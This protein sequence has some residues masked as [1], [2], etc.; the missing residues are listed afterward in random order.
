MGKKEV[1]IIRRRGD[2][3]E[4]GDR[5]N[6]GSPG[7]RGPPGEPGISFTGP[8]GPYGTGF[9]GMTGDTGYTGPTGPY[10]TGDTGAT[11]S[12][13][14]GWTGT[15]G[16]TGPTGP[17]GTGATG[18]TGDTG[19]TGAMGS[20]GAT[21]DTG[22]TGATGA[23]GA[24]GIAGLTGPT[25]SMGT[26]WTGTTGDTGPTGPAGA[27]AS[28]TASPITGDGSVLSPITL[29]P[30]SPPTN[31]SSSW[32]YSPLTSAW[33]IYQNP[34][35]T[36]TTVGSGGMFPSLESAFSN[37]ANFL[38]VISNITFGSG[39]YTLPNLSQRYYIS[40][41]SGVNLEI[42]NQIN[43]NGG[44]VSITGSSITNSILS[45]SNVTTST[46]FT[47]YINLQV[48]NLNYQVGG[49]G[50]I[51]NSE[52]LGS[53]SYFDR[54]VVTNTGNT[55]LQFVNA[56]SDIVIIENVLI[57]NTNGG[58]TYPAISTSS[59]ASRNVFANNIST[60][61]Q[62]SFQIDGEYGNFNSIM[63]R[64]GL[65]NITITGDGNTFSSVI[66]ANVVSV[67]F[68]I[69]NISNVTINYMTCQGFN[70]NPN[71][72]AS[73]CN[74]YNITAADVVI[75]STYNCYFSNIICVN[76]LFV[77]LLTN[78]IVD[79]LTV[80]D[81]FL[82]MRATGSS[83]F[84]I[85]LVTANSATTLNMLRFL[86]CIV[87]G[88]SVVYNGSLGFSRNNNTIFSNIICND[89]IGNINIGNVA[90]ALN[91]NSGCTFNNLMCA[92][93][94]VDNTTL[95]NIDNYRCYGGLNVTSNSI[96]NR[97][98]DGYIDNS[99]TSVSG[100]GDTYFGL[101]VNFNNGTFTVNGA[102]NAIIN[103]MYNRSAGGVANIT[104]S[105]LLAAADRP[106]VVG[107]ITNAAN[108]N[109]HANSSGNVP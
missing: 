80:S 24:T 72:L 65:F 18:A 61:G 97:Y 47:N 71:V 34:S 88:I 90:G 13:G 53:T 93:L 43:W 22:S 17:Y 30:A 81:D 66:N 36:Y 2:T 26:G 86:N 27:N 51:L 76:S 108:V 1:I 54:M 70:L 25:G 32:Y 11:G 109:V 16:D 4:K 94:V 79:G 100:I 6:K 7:C 99:L 10:G 5:G 73:L 40:I 64:D 39:G 28:V 55:A 77:G 52:S 33:G 69:A 75:E 12:M 57:Q 59:L 84:N 9:T 45:C 56:S 20:D 46:L 14:T 96:S 103:F 35:S 38:R 19:S 41:D 50:T 42:S 15:T 107:S 98:S 3:G 31:G 37:N 21:G 62:V 106:L 105:G 83:L 67:G 44:S 78:S 58:Y 60:I 29:L 63:S 101:N 82:S 48:S 8:T 102:G 87:D 95:C 74:F 91:I 104:G 89:P 49:T 68:N 85:S 92:G 23:T